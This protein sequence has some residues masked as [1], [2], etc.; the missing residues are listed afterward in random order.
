M[1]LLSFEAALSRLL[2]T[3]TAVAESETVPTQAARGRVLATPLVSAIAVP[4]LDNSAMD[5]YAVRCADVP[6]VGTRLRI[7]Q[8]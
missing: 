3:A 7:A 5:G 6:A 1:S 4:P 2:A 8:R